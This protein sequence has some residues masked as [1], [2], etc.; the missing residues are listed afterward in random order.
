[1]NKKKMASLLTLG[2]MLS[3]CTSDKQ[4][5][6]NVVE[7]YE[8][9][10]EIVREEK[11][12]APYTHY[13]QVYFYDHFSG[14][15]PY[16]EGYELISVEVISGNRGT[17]SIYVYQNV[18]EVVAVQTVQEKFGEKIYTYDDFGTPTRLLELGEYPEG[19]KVKTLN[20]VD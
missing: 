13:V 14:Q 10:E 20:K 4:Q 16:Y 17:A 15:I 5:E 6:D 9:N 3:G 7:Q 19:Q 1:M 2:L 8:V 12:F 11:V 18:E